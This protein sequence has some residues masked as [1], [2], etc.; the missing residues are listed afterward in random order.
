MV[1]Q[2]TTTGFG[3]KA[4]FFYPEIKSSETLIFFYPVL[5]TVLHGLRTY[6]SIFWQSCS[7]LAITFYVQLRPLASTTRS[8]VS[9]RWASA[10]KQEAGTTGWDQV[11]RLW[12]A[13]YTAARLK[14]QRGGASKSPGLLPILEPMVRIDS[15]SLRRR[16]P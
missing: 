3:Q 14:S 6:E 1:M 10:G 2:S 8:T 16:S 4:H 13:V 15:L 11:L 5:F 12:R 9:A 7:T